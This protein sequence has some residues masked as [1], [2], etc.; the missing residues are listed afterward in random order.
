MKPFLVTLLK[1]L[2]LAL[3]FWFILHH[4]PVLIMPL[5]GALMLAVVIAGLAAI[6]LVLG[7]GLGVVF[8]TVG[9]ALLLAL[10]AALSPVWLPVLAIFGLIALCR[11]RSRRTV[12]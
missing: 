11:P 12:A 3:V 2:G 6:A 1:I 4:A 9:L 5:F 10:A 7:L 8:V